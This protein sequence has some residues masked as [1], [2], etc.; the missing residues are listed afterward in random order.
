MQQ[1]LSILRDKEIVDLAEKT[2][3]DNVLKRIKLEGEE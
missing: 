2:I 3:K 1:N